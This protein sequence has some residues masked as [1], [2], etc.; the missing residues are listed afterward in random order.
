MNMPIYIRKSNIGFVNSD[1]WRALN[2][3][4]FDSVRAKLKGKEIK[5]I[6]YKPKPHQEKALKVAKE[7]FIKEKNSRGKLVFPCGAGKS[8]TGY[9]ITRELKSKSIIV[10]VPSLSLVKQTLEVY[11]RESVANSDKVSWLCVCSDE[12]IGTNDDIAIH[13]NEIGVPCV[14]DKNYIAKWIKDNS[15]NKTI[16]FT[17]YQSGKTI[18]EACKIAKYEFNLRNGWC[19]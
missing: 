17:T 7:Y 5:K 14:T 10:A 15:K 4:F 16:I 18:S 11:L 9:W 2:K 3:E 13:T 1:D 12:G 8:L 19:P 6:P